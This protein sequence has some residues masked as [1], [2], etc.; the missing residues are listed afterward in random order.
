MDKELSDLFFDDIGDKQKNKQEEEREDERV[1]SNL[2]VYQQTRIPRLRRESLAVSKQ[3]YKE[4]RQ[5]HVVHKEVA[6]ESE[7]SRLEVEEQLLLENIEHINSVLEYLG[8][9]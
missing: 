7:L 1:I 2:N 3:V 9:S 8:H 4:H 5:V 6:S